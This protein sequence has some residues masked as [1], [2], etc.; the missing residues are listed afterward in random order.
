MSSRAPAGQQLDLQ[1][2]LTEIWEDPP[3]LLASIATVD[4][5]NIGKRY[6]VTAFVF[7]LLGGL[8][9]VL[10]RLQLSRP[11]QHILSPAV[12]N[13]VFTLHGVTMI[14]W[15]ASPIL[16]GFGNYLVLLLLGARDMA[17]PRLNAFSY[18]AFLLSGLLLYVSPLLGQAPNGGWFAYTPLTGPQF[19]PGLNLD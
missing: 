8:E 1:H 19:S 18:W 5:K 11:G 6:L 7:L 4:H 17:F 15:Y 16:S 2:R 12:Y 13:Q 10:I 14:F 3:G 9:A